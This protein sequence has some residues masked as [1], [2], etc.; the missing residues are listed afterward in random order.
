MNRA[1]ADACGPNC[2]ADFYACLERQVDN[3]DYGAADMCN[4][5]EIMDELCQMRNLYAKKAQQECDF[6]TRAVFMKIIGVLDEMATMYKH[7]HLSMIEGKMN[8][9]EIYK[10]TRAV[11]DIVDRVA[12]IAFEMEGSSAGA[13]LAK[14]QSQLKSLERALA[15]DTEQ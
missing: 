13:K 4:R 1:F 2:A 11:D 10:K 14:Y 8:K 12:R 6:G 15:P 3:E 9:Q 7:A 5:R